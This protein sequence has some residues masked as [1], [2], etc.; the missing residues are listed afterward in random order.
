MNTGTVTTVFE[1]TGFGVAVFE[2]AV[3]EATGFSSGG[4]SY[5][6]GPRTCSLVFCGSSGFTF[7]EKITVVKKANSIKQIILGIKSFWQAKI[8]DKFKSSSFQ[9]GDCLSL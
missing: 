3:F 8:A 5:L 4:F 2:V 9:P 6:T 1:T 7:C